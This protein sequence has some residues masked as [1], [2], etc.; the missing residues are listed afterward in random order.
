MDEKFCETGSKDGSQEKTM[1]HSSSMASSASPHGLTTYCATRKQKMRFGLRGSFQ[2]RRS[3]QIKER[4]ASNRYTNV[5]S[6]VA[7]VSARSRGTRILTIA[8]ILIRSH[9]TTETSR[10]AAG[11]C[12]GRFQH[13]RTH[14]GVV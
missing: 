3:A 6:S 7:S 5:D 12:L 13:W 1:S 10:T 14:I 9:Q 2:D 4:S 11:C 8:L